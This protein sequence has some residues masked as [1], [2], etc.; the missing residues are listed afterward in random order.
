MRREVL[1]LVMPPVVASTLYQ[2]SVGFYGNYHSGYVI[3]T[4]VTT[5]WAVAAASAIL[6]SRVEERFGQYRHWLEL[7]ATAIAVLVMA[8]ADL[9]WLT[10]PGAWE[11][12]VAGNVDMSDYIR[13]VTA[14][15][16]ERAAVWGSLYFG[17]DAGDRT[18]LVQFS[19]MFDV[20]SADFRPAQRYQIAPDYL[21]LSSYETD[22]D[23]VLC[24]AGQQTMI[25]GFGNLFPSERYRL[26]HLVFAPPYGATRVYERVL[27]ERAE[28]PFPSVAAND[29][30]NRQWSTALGAPMDVK[31]SPVQPVVANISLYSSHPQRAALSSVVADLPPGF[32]LIQVALNHPHSTGFILATPGT[33][34]YW[35][36]GWTNFSMPATP[37]LREEQSVFLLVDHLGGACTSADLRIHRPPRMLLLIWSGRFFGRRRMPQ[38][39]PRR[40]AAGTVI[41]RSSLSAA[42]AL[43]QTTQAAFNH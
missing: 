27:K 33:Y 34:F 26:T 16:P 3:V 11:R 7:G 2:L 31:F 10:L 17:L 32:L 22:I 29:G 37:Y 24:L 40:R 35:R 5:F 14:P 13:R 23:S 25:E 18:D 21:A 43:S 6:I 30:T 42:F 4:Y 36:G 41:Y 38:E 28:D 9:Q 1:S 39:L 20:V 12:R 8:G 15:L 19:Q